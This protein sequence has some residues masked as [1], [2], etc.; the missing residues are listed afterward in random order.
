MLTLGIPRG[1]LQRTVYVYFEN[2]IGLKHSG[3]S[4]GYRRCFH[5]VLAFLGCA[6]VDCGACLFSPTQPQ[7]RHPV[8]KG[9]SSLQEMKTIQ[10]CSHVKYALASSGTSVPA[11]SEE[12]RKKQTKNKQTNKGGSAARQVK[13]SFF[14]R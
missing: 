5:R 3:G 10:K 4:N 8:Q 6:Q 13:S 1:C 14:L 7:Q 12:E 2:Q 11:T 9:N